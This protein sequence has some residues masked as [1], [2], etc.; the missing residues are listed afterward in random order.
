VRSVRGRG[1]LLGRELASG[2]P[3]RAVRDLLLE[4]GVLVGTSADPSVLRLLPPLTLKPESARRLAQ[5]LENMEVK[6]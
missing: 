2:V 4:A 5:A 1:L 6:V 3:A